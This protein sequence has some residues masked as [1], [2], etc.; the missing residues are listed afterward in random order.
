MTFEILVIILL[1]ILNGILAMSEIAIVSARKSR[2]Q[3][4]A[5]EGDSSAK[6]ALDLANSPTKFFSTIQIGITLIG[7]LAGAFGGATIAEDISLKLKDIPI[8]GSHSD[9]VSVAVVV[10]AITYLSLIIGELVPKRLALNKP[11]SIAA[12]TAPSMKLLS[13]I[14][15]PLVSVMSISTDLVI[16]VLGIKH[17]EEAPISEEEI[18]VM[19]DQGTAAGVF[20]EAE[21]DMVERVF[22]LGDRRA[23]TL[24]TPRSEIVWLDVNDTPEAIRQKASGHPYSLFP[25]CEG[26]LDDAL[27]VVQAKDLFSCLI[28]DNCIDLKGSLLPPLF[29]PMSAKALTVLERFKE[30]GVHLALVLDEYGSVQGLVTLTDIL[31]AIV[32]DIPHIDDLSEPLIVQ[33]ED[34]SWLVDGMLSVDEFKDAF[35]IETLHEEDSGL[36]QTVGG[37]V[38]MNLERVPI[39]GDRFECCGFRIEVMDM[40]DNRVDKLLVIPL[41]NM[42]GKQ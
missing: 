42:L 22:R 23:E 2:L 29:V 33:R 3:L 9:L 27:G 28:K 26:D 41:D 7:I 31:E 6:T 25:L 19:I 20:E 11:E 12:L 37:F 36:Y 24:M 5:D 15:S 21:Q 14:A 13:K 18:K 17:V 39:M 38:L 1:I 16:K 35:K 30:T 10:L 8:L 32:G 40:D 4:M 34:G